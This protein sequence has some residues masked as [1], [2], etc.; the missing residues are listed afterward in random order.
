MEKSWMSLKLVFHSTSY[1]LILYLKCVH[2]YKLY[3]NITTNC[4]M[5]IVILNRRKVKN[6]IFYYAPISSYVITTGERR[7]LTFQGWIRDY[8]PWTSTNTRIR[9]MV[10][11]ADRENFV[12]IPFF[13]Y[14]GSG[15]ELLFCLW[16]KILSS[17]KYEI[18]TYSNKYTMTYCLSKSWH[19]FWK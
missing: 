5:Q 17:V 18:Y 3:S 4:L 14:T 11:S 2:N 1:L 16:L 6:F 19:S 13:Y 12:L 9:W 10:L 15:S 7:L 8:W